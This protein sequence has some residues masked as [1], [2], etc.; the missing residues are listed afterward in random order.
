MLVCLPD[1]QRTRKSEVYISPPRRVIIPDISLTQTASP[2]P[3]AI[4]RTAVLEADSAHGFL[5][6]YPERE[7]EMF[8]EIRSGENWEEIVTIIE[9]LSPTNKMAGSAGQEPYLQ[10]SRIRSRAEPICWRSIC[11]VEARIPLQR[12]WSLL[13]ERGNW[14]CLICLHRPMQRL[15]F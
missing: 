4:G 15:P 12:L 3:A 14:D 9:V 7:T 8:L 10:N 1:W 11:C 2:T 13:R 5:I 6:A